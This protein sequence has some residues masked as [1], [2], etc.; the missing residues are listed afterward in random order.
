MFVINALPKNLRV[1]T[2]LSL[3]LSILTL[4]FSLVTLGI[5]S[6]FL[7]PSIAFIT[8]V[9]LLVVLIL[10]HKQRALTTPKSD[11]ETESE[12]PLRV[13]AYS[14]LASIVLAY[15][16]GLC[17]FIASVACMII[18]AISSYRNGITLAATSIITCYAAT[19]QTVVWFAFVGMI[20]A[21]RRA[22]VSFKQGNFVQQF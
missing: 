22:A 8:L 9:Y 10:E 15:L 7:A 11:F 20:H 21:E 16:F 2:W 12:H 6:F 18:L 5:A 14:T 17:W 1:L 4:A 3:S 19:A 13:P